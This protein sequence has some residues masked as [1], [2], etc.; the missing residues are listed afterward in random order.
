MKTLPR[1]R[2]LV[3]VPE[4]AQRVVPE[5]VD[6]D[7]L[8]VARGG[9]DA[10]VLHIHPGQLRGLVAGANQT[11]GR[12]DADVEAGPLPVAFDDRLARRP[13]NALVGVAVLRC[14]QVRMR[15]VDEPEARIDRVVARLVRVVVE[16][17]GN[18]SLADVTGKRAQHLSRRLVAAGGQEQ[19]G[20]RDEGVAAPIAE[21]RIPRQ[22][23]RA[24]RAVGVMT[25]HHEVGRGANELALRRR[26][27]RPQLQ[28][29]P[30]ALVFRI[31]I[32][33]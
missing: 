19:S 12:I 9:D 8:A 27:H 21:P 6:L 23:R 10:F 24:R 32:E 29:P 16:A 26:R 11:V 22:N 14:R 25:L 2:G 33:H 4:Q 13:E 30:A 3:I 18:H 28:A 1:A 15:G 7:G 20:Q 5:R 17:V 31:P